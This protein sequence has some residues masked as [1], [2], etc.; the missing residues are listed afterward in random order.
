LPS[1]CICYFYLKQ[2]IMKLITSFI[3]LVLLLASCKKEKSKPADNSELGDIKIY[4]T[5]SDKAEPVL[6]DAMLLLHSFEYKDAAEKFRETREL[7]PDCAMAVWG[8]AMSFNHPLWREQNLRKARELMELLGETKDEQREKFKTEYEKDLFDA[9]SILYGDGSKVERDL[10]YSNYLGELYEKYPDNHEVASMYALSILGSVRGGRDYEVYAKGARIAQSVIEENPNHP[11]ALH[12]LI[13]SYDDPENAHKA[14][15]AANSYSQ[16]APDAGHALHMPSHIYVALGMWDEV[17]RSNIA[18]WEASVKRKA[19]KNLTNDALNYH[20]FKWLMYG[21]LQKGE[22][23]KARK[24]VAD[25][26]AYAKELPSSRAANHVVM[27]KAAYFTESGEWGDELLFDTLDYARHSFETRSVH[28]FLMGM[29]AFHDEDKV[30]LTASKDSM[31]AIINHYTNEALTSSGAAMCS[32]N[33]SRETPTQVDLERAKV[34][35]MELEAAIAMMEGDNE[36]VETILKSAVDLE[37]ATSYNYGPPAIVKPASELYAE[38]LLEQ[39]RPDDAAKQFEL[40]L[41]R[42][43]G[44]LIPTQYMNRIKE[45]S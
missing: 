37:Q 15:E 36:K 19:R 24:L 35:K 29:K 6:K 25:M 9:M 43:P 31:F 5:V 20:A 10:A 33:Y 12:Y 34:L 18:S 22:N 41:E 39:N 44:R 7:D 14:L 3:V 23:D 8:E 1:A 2:S 38:W 28:A 21:Y 40:V 42:A 16:V 26:E 13:H 27:M 30:T 17:I 11:G 32:G 45:M 4:A